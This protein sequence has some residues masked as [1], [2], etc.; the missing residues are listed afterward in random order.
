[1]KN[2]TIF[3]TLFTISTSVLAAEAASPSKIV[4]VTPSQL[5]AN[6]A[7]YHGKLVHVR[8]FVNV[9]FEQRELYDSRASSLTE[10][11]FKTCVTIVNAGRILSNMKKYNHKMLI[12]TGVFTKDI[13]KEPYL[14]LAGCNLT[15]INLADQPPPEIVLGK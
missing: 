9:G 12:L 13:R 8:G 6:R 11:S 3:L 15:A 4:T 7:F 10:D 14:Q 5:N 2:F 1:M